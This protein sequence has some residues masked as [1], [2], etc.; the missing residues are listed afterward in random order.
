[1]SGLAEAGADLLGGELARILGRHGGDL[2]S[3]VHIALADG[4]EAIVKGGPAPLVE[5]EMLE[6]IA[7]TGAPAPKVLA[8]SETALAMEVL[9]D[10]GGLARAWPSLGRA[11]ASLH[12]GRGERYGWKR[13][14]AFGP[15]VIV[16]DFA[17]DWPAFWGER[18]LLTSLPHIGSGLARRIE[19]LVA[20]LPNRLPARPAPA[21]LHGDMWAGNVLVAGSE[22]SGLIDPACYY[23]DGE[24][25]LAMLA[26][27]GGPG[28]DFYAAYGRL[29]PG[30]EARR[31][32]YQLW[33]ALVHLRLFGG[34]YQGM[35]ER[36]L[37]A[38][39]T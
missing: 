2:S 14:F 37:R 12:A 30:H 17:E 24:V 7:A 3:L 9:P 22:V 39:G 4:R 34:G 5:A 29:E 21:L 11:L 10:T 1:M 31:H 18:R 27:F 23:G 19:G 15:V 28:E 6:A 32:I 33:P 25:D 35:V 36:L 16:N 20:D 26:L 8:A 13:D 38:A